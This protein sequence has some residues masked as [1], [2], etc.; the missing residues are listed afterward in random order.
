MKKFFSIKKIILM[1]VFIGGLVYFF[2]MP[3]FSLDQAFRSDL[4][5]S[6]ASGN[7]LPE[8]W[9]TYL[10]SADIICFLPPYANEKGMN[11]DL[12]D[13]ARAFLEKK[14]NFIFGG[15]DDNTWWII[16]ISNREVKFMLEMASN[17]R[18]DSKIVLCGNSNGLVLQAIPGQPSLFNVQFN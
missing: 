5:A 18:P 3:R 14:L 13:E 8:K 16:G 6:L 17:L 15:V 9:E 11:I 7:P 12:S 1:S 4:K 10:K 2:I